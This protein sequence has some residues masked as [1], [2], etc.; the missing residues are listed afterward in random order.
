MHGPEGGVRRISSRIDEE[1][2]TARIITQLDDVLRSD[3]A[4]KSGD[5]ALHQPTVS[6]KLRFY[7]LQ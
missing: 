5:I 7:L 1:D 3:I 6:C 4:R 2:P